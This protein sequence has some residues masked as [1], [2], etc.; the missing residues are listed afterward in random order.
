[1]TSWQDD[2]RFFA[3]LTVAFIAAALNSPRLG[4]V[5][6]WLAEVSDG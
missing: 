1:M 4:R 3:I 5:A 2:A 6:T